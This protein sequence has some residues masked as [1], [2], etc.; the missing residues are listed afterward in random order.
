MPPDR[1]GGG[2]GGSCGPSPGYKLGK[3]ERAAECFA[4]AREPSGERSGG[5]VRFSLREDATEAD[6]G[7]DA[8]DCEPELAANDVDEEVEEEGRRF[9]EE[10][11]MDED[12]WD[13]DRD[14]SG[15]ATA[16]PPLL[17]VAAV[18]SPGDLLPPAEEDDDDEV[19]EPGDNTF[20][21][22]AGGVKLPPFNEPGV[23][24][25]L[26]LAPLLGRASSGLCDDDDE[27]VSGS[28]AGIVIF[29][30]VTNDEL[31][32]F[33]RLLLL[34]L[35]LLFVR[36]GETLPEMDVVPML[37]VAVLLL[38]FDLWWW[39][40]PSPFEEDPF[41]FFVLAPPVPPNDDEEEVDRSEEEDVDNGP[42]VPVPESRPE[43]DDEEEELDEEDDE[44]DKDGQRGFA[45]G[46][47]APIWLHVW[48]NNANGLFFASNYLKN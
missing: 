11:M 29:F 5:P 19:A 22:T 42:A 44:E 25:L 30:S 47:S 26:P 23:F 12:S 35:L 16:A 43:E 20:P 9:V 46:G 10:M 4:T 14:V 48:A 38:L 8:A 3:W 36:L 2:G 24:D 41:P 27:L 13:F 40:F 31:L 39:P 28:S 1:A 15:V 21:E 18:I 34:L 17:P 45:L 7:T 32:P 33:T 37:E 6:R